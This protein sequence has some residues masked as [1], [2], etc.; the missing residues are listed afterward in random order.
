MHQHQNSP[1]LQYPFRRYWSSH[2]WS[3][4]LPV[5]AAKQSRTDRKKVIQDHNFKLLYQRLDT[6][7]NFIRLQERI[8]KRLVLEHQNKRRLFHEK[9]KTTV[10]PRYLHPR[11]IDFHIYQ[12]TP[13]LDYSCRLTWTVQ[14]NCKRISMMQRTK[15]ASSKARFIESQ[16]KWHPHKNDPSKNSNKASKD[17]PAP[18]MTPPSQST[19]STNHLRL[20]W[21]HWS[22]F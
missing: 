9:L 22:K 13:R 4:I 20:F 18:A 3:E 12:Q 11:R 7:D 14:R 10:R 6:R 16:P 17:S 2:N 5:E 1:T 15:W 21:S 8:P 19:T